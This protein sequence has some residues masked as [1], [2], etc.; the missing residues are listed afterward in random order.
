MQELKK[1]S[2]GVGSGFESPS[3]KGNYYVFCV[4]V[5]EG[6]QPWFRTVEADA[7]WNV[8]QKQDGS[9][10]I[11]AET[12]TALMV[13][14]PL[15]P[16]MS[17]HVSDEAYIGA[18]EAWKLAKDAVHSDWTVLTD[19]HNLLPDLPSAFI[20]AQDL[21]LNE[22]EYLGHE[23]QAEL[24][25][26]LQN[27]PPRRVQLSV[28]KV[29]NDNL[30]SREKIEAIREVLEAAGLQV[31]DPVNPLPVVNESEVRLVAWMAVKGTRS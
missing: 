27:V 9:T 10:V 29:L 31:P 16:Y 1:M 23:A 7:Q 4:R 3:L 12:L 17:R 20:D 13:A 21:V 6:N 22:G 8:K 30:S 15:D 19:P 24:R 25:A 2:L 14:D 18:F 28:R 11:H 26:K 5:G